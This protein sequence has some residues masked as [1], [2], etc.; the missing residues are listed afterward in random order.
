MKKQSNRETIQ[1]IIEQAVARTRISCERGAKDAYKETER[2]LYAYPI[3]KLKIA[4]LKEKVEEIQAFDAPSKSKS[5]VSFSKTGIRLTPDEITEALIRDTTADIAGNE[6]EIENIEKALD[7]VAEDEYA[8]IIPLKYF[9]C[10]SD[11]ETA[12]SV[13]CSERTVRYQKSRL[14]NRLAVR[15]YGI[16][17]L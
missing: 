9:E 11:E 12:D 13:K 17:A 10:K 16:D 4:D 15:L 1:E 6:A 3:I 7:T 8:A 14:V 5:V 2:R